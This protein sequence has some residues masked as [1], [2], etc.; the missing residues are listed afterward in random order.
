MSDSLENALTGAIEE[1]LGAIISP[2]LDALGK[3][4]GAVAMTG[5]GTDLRS[6]FDPKKNIDLNI[7]IASG[8]AQNIA[9][10]LP[11]VAVPLIVNIRDDIS[12]AE[13]MIPKIEE[14]VKTAFKTLMGTSEILD[15]F[16]NA[17]VAMGNVK[18]V[19]EALT[20]TVEDITSDEIK[21]VVQNFVNDNFS[22]P[23]LPT[24]LSTDIQS[25]LSNAIFKEFTKAKD[26]FEELVP[27]ITGN[28]ITDLQIKTNPKI[29]DLFNILEIN[30]ELTQIKIL[31]FI[32]NDK[33]VEAINL[34][35]ETTG[36]LPT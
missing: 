14:D 28:V 26:T 19:A 23:N 21:G 35:E 3:L 7:S 10:I 13:K 33:D 18:G 36:Y 11:Q 16:P 17:I 8:A 32:Y 15:G 1:A 29:I 9:R 4:E 22:L 6:A 25:I 31:K 30:D 2:L 12:V 34:I 24:F 5:S 27:T 20:A